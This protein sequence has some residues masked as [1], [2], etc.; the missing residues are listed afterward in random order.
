MKHGLFLLVGRLPGCKI[1]VK[2]TGSRLLL[3]F[4]KAA[5]I[6]VFPFIPL[7]NTPLHLAVMMGHKGEYI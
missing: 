6:Y 4:S 7:G 5:Q 3:G 1:A 2:D